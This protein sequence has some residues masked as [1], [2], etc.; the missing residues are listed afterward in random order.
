VAQ[1]AWMVQARS[2]FSVIPRQP[3]IHSDDCWGFS[4]AARGFLRHFCL[5]IP[6]VRFPLPHHESS[7]SVVISFGRL[8][9]QC[10]V[11]RE[12]PR[13]NC[14][15]LSLIVFAAPISACSWY[16]HST[17]MN[18]SQSRLDL[19]I[20]PQFLHSWLECLGLTLI[21]ICPGFAAK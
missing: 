6:F 20:L 17:Q 16:P 9:I 18:F 15:T 3:L 10:L 7:L 5:N 4:A 12:S 1:W 13:T 21:T 2:I 14:K 19:S 11:T 8:G